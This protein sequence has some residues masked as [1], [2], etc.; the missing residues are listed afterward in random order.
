MKIAVINFSGN[1]GKST[2]AANLLLPRIDS[3]R[4][5]SIES[6]NVDAGADGVEVERMLGKQYDRLMSEMFLEDAAIVDV[7][8][9]NISDFLKFMQQYNRSHEF[10]D[11]YLVPVVKEKK[12]QADTINTIDALRSIGIPA[13]KILL[14]FNKVEVDEQETVEDLF[15]P[16]FGAHMVNQ[17]F[18]LNQDAIIYRNDVFEKIKHLNMPISQLIADET[19]YRRKAREAGNSDERDRCVEIAMAKMLAVSAEKNLAAV[20][21]ILFH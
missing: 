6:S 17:N 21:R 1:V 11:Y 8:A 14:V 13:G 18:V 5:F 4:I 16:I 10:F 15:A 20:F 19:D 2:L 12:Q 7:G 3:A 9:S